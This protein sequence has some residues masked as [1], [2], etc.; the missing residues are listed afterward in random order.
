MLHQQMMRRKTVPH[1]PPPPKTQGR[2]ARRQ[3]PHPRKDE[4]RQLYRE[5][6]KAKGIDKGDKQ[7]KKGGKKKYLRETDDVHS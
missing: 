7:C 2:E 5:S 4:G 6:E 3:H 1:E